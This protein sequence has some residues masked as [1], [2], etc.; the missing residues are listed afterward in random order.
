VRRLPKSKI[1][2]CGIT[3]IFDLSSVRG[4]DLVSTLS[5]TTDPSKKKQA[6]ENRN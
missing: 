4:I 3:V 6:E 1:E 5:I 2:S